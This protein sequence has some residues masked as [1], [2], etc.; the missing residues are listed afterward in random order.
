MLKLLGALCIFTACVCAGRQQAR[1]LE[2]RRRFLR[3]AHQG[4]LALMR[5][6]DYA[7]TPMNQALPAAAEMAG[8]AAPLFLSAAD[9]LARGGGCTAGEAWQK[10]LKAA[11]HIHEEDRR[12]LALAGE[13]LGVSDAA[14]QLK[15]LELLRLRIETAEREAAENAARF[16]KIWRTMGW[17]SGAILVL[18]LL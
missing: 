6:I 15:S 7:A 8:P 18:L 13:G 12:L 11:D 4:L 17:S 10:A 2:K 5:E 1:Q 14:Q 16:G 3:G 9:H